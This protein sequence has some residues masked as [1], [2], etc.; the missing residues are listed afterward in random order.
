LATK[1]ALAEPPVK[2]R[3]TQV[4][5]IFAP[6]LAAEYEQDPA[7][8]NRKYELT[9]LEV[10]GVYE[11]QANEESV[12]PPSRPHVLIAVKG[13]QRAVACDLA[14]SPTAVDRWKKLVAGQPIT[15]CGTY[16]KDLFLHGCELLRV[17]ASADERYKGKEIELVGVVDT[18]AV[19]EE[20]SGYPTLKL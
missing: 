8:C 18:A 12:R 20:G 7:A 17:A 2:P 3:S 6:R 15:V 13:R 19:D 16:S 4:V 9:L 10:S 14:G 1:T 5:K 11:R